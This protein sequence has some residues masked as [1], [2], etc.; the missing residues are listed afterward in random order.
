MSK[1][2]IQSNVP[3]HRTMYFKDILITDIL[4]KTAFYTTFQPGMNVVTRETL[5]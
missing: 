1:P 3:T 4:N 2:F 5:I